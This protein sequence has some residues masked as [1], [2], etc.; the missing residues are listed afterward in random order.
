MSFAARAARRLGAA[1][2]LIGGAPPYLHRHR[3]SGVEK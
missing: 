1:G 2:H 3:R